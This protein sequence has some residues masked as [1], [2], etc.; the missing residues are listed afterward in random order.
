MLQQGAFLWTIW[1]AHHSWHC[2]Q[3]RNPPSQNLPDQ[4]IPLLLTNGEATPPLF[5]PSPAITPDAATD[6]TDAN[7]ADRADST[8][9]SPTEH[10]SGLAMLAAA[11]SYVAKND[12]ERRGG[13]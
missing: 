3:R 10:T 4:Q 11:S 7:P 2:A 9:A 13:Y 12:E 1:N 8:D 5:G 6:S